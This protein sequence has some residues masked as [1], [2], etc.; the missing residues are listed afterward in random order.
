[1]LEDLTPASFLPHV[2][3]QFAVAADGSPTLTLTLAS[4]D[5]FA[6]RSGARRTQPFSLLFAGPAEPTLPQRI[7]RLEHPAIGTLEIFLV[8]VG[9]GPEGSARYE[10]VFN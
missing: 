7:H 5:V 8:P 10:A 2:G 3:T 9:P 6:E 4:V 1:M